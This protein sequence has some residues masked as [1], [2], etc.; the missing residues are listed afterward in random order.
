MGCVYARKDS[1]WLKFKNAEGSW[2]YRNSGLKKG[3]ER[4]AEALLKKI[5]NLVASGTELA[6]AGPLTVAR[7]AKVWL[8]GRR[9]KGLVI[10]D[11]YDSRLTNHILPKL[12]AMKLRDVLPVHIEE[13]VKALQDKGLAPRTIRHIYFQTHGMFQKAVRKGHLVVNPCNLEED[14]LPAKVDRNPEWRSTAIYSRAEVEQIIIDERIPED[15]RMYNALLFLAGIRF[16]E[17]SALRWRHYDPTAQP[18]GRITIARSYSTKLKKEKEVKTKVPR[19][20][21]AH[22]VL[23]AL[24]AEWKLSGWPKMIG[25]QPQPD[26]L[27]IPSRRGLNRSSNHMLKKLHQDLGRLGM[28][29]RRQHDLRRTF[30]SLCLGDGASKDILRWT[31]HAPEGDVIDDYTTLVW[32]PLCREVAKLEIT[33]RR[34]QAIAAAN[35][36][37]SHAPLSDGVTGRVTRPLPDSPSDAQLAGMAWESTIEDLR[38]GRDLNPRPPA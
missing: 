35:L 1:L 15:R 21:P 10:A 7:W 27:L 8:D 37:N 32:N 4:D 11:D 16:G 31:T 28:R 30:I 3:Q 34:P 2:E 33:L 18:L 17:A 23:A 25:R 12:G 6:D 9:A 26:D 36:A 13:L 29:P 24:L 19:A 22:P 20:V 14:D 38:G 5:E